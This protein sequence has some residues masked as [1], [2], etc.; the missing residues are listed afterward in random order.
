MF[1]EIAMVLH[2]GSKEN[3]CSSQIYMESLLEDTVKTLQLEEVI[4]D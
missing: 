2:K 4:R 1:S 3:S